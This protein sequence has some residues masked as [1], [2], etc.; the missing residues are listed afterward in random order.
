MCN[1]KYPSDLS[2]GEWQYLKKCLPKQK[3]F[4]RPPK[5]QRREILN[6]I[7]YLLRTGCAWR[8][9]PTDYPCWKTVYHYFRE[10]RVAGVWRKVNKRLRRLL[11]K[12]AGKQ[13]QSSV[14]ILDSQ[15]TKTTDCAREEVGFDSGKRIKGRKRH[16]LV[17]SLG[18]L[19]H[20][21]VH[22][23][24]ISETAGAR[25]VLQELMERWWRLKLIWLDGGYKNSLAEWIVGVKRWRKIKLE[26]VRRL[27]GETGFHILPKRWIVERTFGWLSKHRRLSKDYESLCVTSEAMVHAAMIR[28]M[29]ARLDS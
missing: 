26:W 29:L 27:E 3:R 13:A 18:L 19:I 11:R 10:F 24:S 23:A 1:K 25:L 14:A 20:V 28:L 15:S 5:H 9:V 21:V 7:F 12:R 8:Y 6:A 16:I 2:D 17:D 22:A 4:G